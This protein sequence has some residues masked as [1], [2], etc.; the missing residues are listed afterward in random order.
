MRAS[1]TG[2]SVSFA[3]CTTK[4]GGAP[5]LTRLMGEARSKSPG[6]RARSF[7]MTMRSRMSAS[8]AWDA[9]VRFVKS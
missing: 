3:P 1:A 6:Q 9:P 8:P 5:S 2:T 7:F 4:K